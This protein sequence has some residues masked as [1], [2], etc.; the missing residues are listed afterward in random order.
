MFNIG[1]QPSGPEVGVEQPLLGAHHRH[2]RNSMALQQFGD[3][4]SRAGTG[5]LGKLRV[6]FVP[7][8]QTL[9]FAGEERL[10]RPLGI[11]Q[12]RN[13]VLP[14]IFASNG[15]RYPLI[16]TG[17]G[18]IAIGHH[19]RVEVASRLKDSPGHGVFHQPNPVGY[20]CGPQHR[21]IDVLTFSRLFPAIERRY[22]CK[23]RV[24]GATNITE[25][26]LQSKRPLP[27]ISH[28]GVQSG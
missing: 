1:V 24:Q 26:V 27:L 28:R 21:L 7:V 25:G 15:N 13:H 20:H 6:H 5:P 3:F 18:V 12:S 22:D 17:T 9:V 19:S 11:T 10:L 8:F 14:L 23:N 4:L 16:I 2:S